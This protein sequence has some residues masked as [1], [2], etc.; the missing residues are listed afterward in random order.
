MFFTVGATVLA[1]TILCQDLLEY[2]HNR[3]LLGKVDDSIGKLESLNADYDELLA[4]MEKDP[5]YIKRI[6]TA[7]LGRDP[8]EPN[9]VYPRATVEKLAAAK[10][11]LGEETNQPGAEPNEP[12]WLNRCCQSPHRHILFACG[13]VLV[14]ISFIFFG[15]VKVTGQQPKAPP[16]VEEPKSQ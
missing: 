5:N 4:E 6:A 14:L 1:G 12:L 16:K 10:A 2:F 13:A 8:C 3:Q 9:T 15:P 7:T 11:A